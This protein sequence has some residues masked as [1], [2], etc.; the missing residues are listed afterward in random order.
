MIT[1]EAFARFDAE[2]PNVWDLLC[3]SIN[4]RLES[5]VRRWSMRAALHEI[6]WGLSLD[7]N[8]DLTPH[9]A[10]KWLRLHPQYPRFFEVRASAAD[11]DDVRSPQLE[12]L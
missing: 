8:N 4:L 1:N 12:L 11:T 6:R 10:R 7:A 3:Q 9:Y 5:G 2:N